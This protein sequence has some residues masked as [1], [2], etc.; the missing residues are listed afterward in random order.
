MIF[1]AKFMVSF[2]E[3]SKSFNIVSISKVLIIRKIFEATTPR[4]FKRY[5][6][7]NYKMAIL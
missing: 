6:D 3:I 2:Q 7:H 5:Y 4:V 1:F